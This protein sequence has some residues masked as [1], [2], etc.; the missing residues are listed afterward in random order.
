MRQ[1]KWAALVLAATIG[2]GAAQAGTIERACLG[3]D[4]PKSRALCGCIQQ[5]AD[6]TL[7]GRDQRIAAR[8]FN[9]PHRAQEM[10]TSDR[11]GDEEFWA[12]YVRFGMTAESYCSG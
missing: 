5:A 2:A 3:S 6:A 9:D 7:T 11:S 1:A 4:R 8:F 10:R 12:R